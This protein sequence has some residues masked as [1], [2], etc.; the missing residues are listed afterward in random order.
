MPA[1]N[2]T[3]FRH[4]KPGEGDYKRSDSGGLSMLV[5]TSGSKLW[6]FS[7]RFDAKQKLLAL[8]QYPV[9]S[10]ADA[11]I[12]R[13]SAKKLLV[14]G[15]DPSVD[16]KEERRQARMARSNTFEAVAKEL[17]DSQAPDREITRAAWRQAP[18]LGR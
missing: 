8:G 3:Y 17:M 7:Y 14:E 4:L 16:R 11:R 6:R 12:K 1:K 10:L 15:I 13:D 18:H 5:T 2:D 9:T